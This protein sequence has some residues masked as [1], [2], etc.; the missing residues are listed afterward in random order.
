MV[1]GPFNPETGELIPRP[2][3]EADLVKLCR[4]LQRRDARFVV[5]G[6]LAIILAGLARH[7]ACVARRTS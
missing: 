6:G 7:R 5:V 2:P 4:Y 3:L 1:D